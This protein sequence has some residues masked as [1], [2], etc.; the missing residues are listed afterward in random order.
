VSSGARVLVIAEIGSVHDG[1]LGNALRLIDAASEAGADAV[2]F[3]T[4]IADAETLPDAPAPAYFSSESRIEYFRRTSFSLD[5]WIAL[6]ARC[7][8]RNT[9]FLSSP[10]SEEAVDLLE[11][12]GV[13]RYKIPSGEVSNIPL[14]EKIAA[15]RKPVILSSGMSSWEE[16]DRAVAAVRRFHN[17]LAVLNCTSEYPCPDDR[18]GL[19]VLAE[20][21]ARYGTP[22]GLSDHTLPPYAALAAVALGALIIEKHFTFSRLMYGSD[23]KHSMEPQEFGDMVRGIRSIERMLAS[24]VDKADIGR[25]AGMKRIFEKSIVARGN[26]AA[27]TVI[28]REMLAFKKPGDGIPAA[29]VDDVVG[30][31]AVRPIPGDTKLRREDLQ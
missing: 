18:V 12:V 4:H 27:G 19:N 8:E 30:R 2:K 6:K 11:A 28:T 17:D 5:Q 31:S 10:F 26:I 16:L 3:Q 25:F 23:A 7:L 24:Y 22:V 21:R 15:T 9:L 14:I 29:A 13:E 1:S 20:M